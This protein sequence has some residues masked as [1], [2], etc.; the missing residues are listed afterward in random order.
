MGQ[1]EAK[2]AMPACTQSRPGRV[3]FTPILVPK[4]TR[5]GTRWLYRDP[6]ANQGYS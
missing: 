1:R 6:D 2:P 3:V 5:L 4:A